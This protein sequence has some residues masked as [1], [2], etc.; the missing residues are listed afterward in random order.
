MVGVVKRS[1]PIRRRRRR[2][3]TRDE[4]EAS[5][6]FGGGGPCEVHDGHECQ[7]RVQSHHVVEKA[8]LKSIG[9]LDLLWDIR[10]RMRVCTWRHERHTGAYERIPLE[11]VP[12]GARAFARELGLDWWLERIYG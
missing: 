11:L 6:I 9:R 5:A 4:I 3:R 10:N 1:S 2:A 7:G 12:A 8:K